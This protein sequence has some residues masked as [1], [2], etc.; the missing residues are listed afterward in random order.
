MSARHGEGLNMEH[1]DGSLVWKSILKADKTLENGFRLKLGDGQASLF[2]DSWMNK[3]LLCNLVHW[4]QIHDT[5]LRV[6]DVLR[7]GVWH[8]NDIFTILPRDLKTSILDMNIFLDYSIPNCIAWVGSM[9]EVY[10]ANFGYKWLLNLETHNTPSREAP[11]CVLHCL[12]DCPKATCIWKSYSF[13]EGS[14]FWVQMDPY[15]WVQYGVKQH[16]HVFAAVSWWVW[17]DRYVLILRLVFVRY[18]SWQPLND[19]FVALNVDGSSLGNP[20]HAGYGDLIRNAQGEWLCGFVGHVGVSN[21]IHME[22]LVVLLG[23]QLAWD[24]GYCY[25][26][27]LIVLRQYL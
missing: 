6:K 13:H 18:V 24:S 19:N 8:F 14:E 22:L 15:L 16:P 26:V 11:E 21:N 7:E 9:D 4:V 5:N 1:T 27:G 3:E 2:F 20:G 25:V 12:C 17:K 10:S 23:L